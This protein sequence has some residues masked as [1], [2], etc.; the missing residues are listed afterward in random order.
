MTAKLHVPAYLQVSTDVGG[1]PRVAWLAALPDRVEELTARWA[2]DLGEPFEPGGN[3]SWVAPGTDRDGR[4]V[5]LK[6]AWEHTEA[7]H[8]AEGLAVLGGHGAVEVYEFE[9]MRAGTVESHRDAAGALPS[10]DRAARAP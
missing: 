2:L 3:C 8:E 7:R 5:V 9:H 6:V 4:D 10:R 1:P